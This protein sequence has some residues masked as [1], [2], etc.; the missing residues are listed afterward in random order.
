MTADPN[1]RFRPRPLRLDPSAGNVTDPARTRVLVDDALWTDLV[2]S[3]YTPG[4]G[5]IWF[6]K[7][8]LDPAV[9]ATLPG[10]WRDVDHIVSTPTVRRDAP[11]LPTVADALEH[12]EPV[13]T[14]GE[15]P[16]RVEIR[17]VRRTGDGGG[18]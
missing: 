15:G 9:K 14:F 6:Y 3:G 10:G 5:A 18:R 12:S 13:A 17:T 7:A 4:T 16:Q 8:D 1:A 11:D 2:H